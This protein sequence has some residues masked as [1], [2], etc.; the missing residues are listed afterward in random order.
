MTEP[1]FIAV[2]DV[3]KTNAKLVLHDLAQR[4]DLFVASEPNAVRHDGPYPHYDTDRLWSFL[5][6]SLAA[7]AAEHRVDA[8]SVTTHGACAA[9]VDDR[10]LVLPVLDYESALPEET[11]PDYERLRPGFEESFSPGLPCG[12]NLGRQLYW[13]ERLHPDSFARARHI[14]LYPQYWVWRLTGV[15]ASEVTSLGCHTDLWA[16]AS[17]T[18]SSLV[19][20][21]GWRMKFPPLHSA[22]AAVGMLRPEIAAQAGLGERPVPVHCGIH[23]SNA[24]L[25]PHILGRQAPLSVVST[26]TWVIALSVGGAMGGALA[27]LDPARDMLANVDALGRPVPSSRFMGG[28]EYDLLTGRSG[29]VPSPAETG[30]VLDGAVMALPTFSPGTGPFPSHTGRWTADPASLS[31]GERAAA[32]SLYLALMTG[33]MLGAMAAGGPTIV[34]GPFAR[35]DLFLEALGALTGRPV[36]ASSGTTGTSAGAAL[37]AAGEADHGR[38]EVAYR[39]TTAPPDVARRILGYGVRWRGLL[40]GASAKRSSRMAGRPDL[41]PVSSA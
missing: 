19:R 12:L 40:D 9:L 15:A 17:G 28:R 36:L 24:S 4:A 13:L 3:G 32:A 7:C 39:Q 2:F 23:D 34:E 31:P 8:I 38:D 22:F 1:R 11:G 18:F 33:E 14:L 21:A 16:P 35:N 5:L 25:L 30:R 6:A 20:R 37:L 26:G 41:D 27:R 29:A 10:E